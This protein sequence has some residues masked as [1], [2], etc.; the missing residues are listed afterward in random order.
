MCSL[1]WIHLNVTLHLQGSCKLV[2]K[3][4]RY[5]VILRGLHL[6]TPTPTPHNWLFPTF[7]AFFPFKGYLF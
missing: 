3:A 6:A 2:T 4:D 1:L 5:N 7:S